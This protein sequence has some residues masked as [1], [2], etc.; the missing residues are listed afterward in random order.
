MTSRA[1]GKESG[2][3]ST[4]VSFG[5]APV[6]LN[7]FD[8]AHDL[9]AK[10]LAGTRA[11]D[12]D[13]LAFELAVIEA[14]GNVVEHSRASELR[15]TITTTDHDLQACLVDDGIPFDTGGVGQDEPP[16]DG[17]ESGRGLM[18]IKRLCTEVESRRD[19]GRNLLTLRRRFDRDGP[20]DA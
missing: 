2:E 4:T 12:A 16:A 6:G 17:A 8:P 11:G 3:R 9:V 7:C 18:L 19:N 1:R 13:R 20:R 5:C 14:V 15:V 10:A